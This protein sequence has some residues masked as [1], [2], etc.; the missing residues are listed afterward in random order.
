MPFTKAA[1]LSDDPWRKVKPFR[2]A[3][4]AVVRFLSDDECLRVVNACEARSATRQRRVGHRLPLW[5][6][7]ADA[8]CRLQR[9]SWNHLRSREQ[10]GQAAPRRADGRGARVL[11]R[12]TAEP[13]GPSVCSATM[14][15][16]GAVASAA[17]LGRPPAVAPNRSAATFHILRHTYASALAMSG[18]PMGV[19][20]AQL[21]HA[22]PE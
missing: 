2:E 16:W 15:A 19:I 7:D 12:L 8:R 10:V 11:R 18:V 5:R 4:A 6:V 13:G 17:S 22:T 14:E 1:S 20:A 21:G 9:R 3:G